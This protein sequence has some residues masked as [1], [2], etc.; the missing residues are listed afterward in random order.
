M[1]FMSGFVVAGVISFAI[2]YEELTITPASHLELAAA[3]IAVGAGLAGGLTIMCLFYVGIFLIGAILGFL[4]FVFFVIAI[5]Q[6]A[7]LVAH[8]T[9]TYVMAG[10]ISVGGGVLALF[11]Q[12]IIIVLSTA[13][14]GAFGVMAA[15]DYFAQEGRALLEIKAATSSSITEPAICW[16]SYMTFIIWPVFFIGGTV[17]QFRWTSRNFDH[18]RPGKRTILNISGRRG[19]K[20]DLELLLPAEDA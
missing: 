1:L 17:V 14:A 20:D 6:S 15:V 13:C 18:R 11:M 2:A 10:I 7:F 5:H 12:K 16:Y 8:L 9:V 19:D 3:G 4:I